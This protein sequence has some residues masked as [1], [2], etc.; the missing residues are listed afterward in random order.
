MPT[1]EPQF[2]QMKCYVNFE[3][4]SHKDH[5]VPDSARREPWRRVP[6]AACPRGGQVPD[7]NRGGVSPRRRV[8]ARA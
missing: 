4:M 2:A 5:I 7:V 1:T 3:A 6:A 8:P